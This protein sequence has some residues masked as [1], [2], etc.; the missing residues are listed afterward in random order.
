MAAITYSAICLFIRISGNVE[1]PHFINFIRVFAAPVITNFFFSDYSGVVSRSGYVIPYLLSLF[2][3]LIL[4]F[5]AINKK[6]IIV[7]A[8][9]WT[10]IILAILFIGI[11]RPGYVEPYSTFNIGGGER[12]IFYPI[13]MLLI[14]F[15]RH[16]D[17]NDRT[18]ISQIQ[19][20]VICGCLALFFLNA[21]ANYEFHPF[22]D[23]E[24][25]SY[26][27]DFD[28]KGQFSCIIPINPQ[29][30]Y[31][32]IP[33]NHNSSYYQMQYWHQLKRIE[34]GIMSIDSVG[35]KQYS[36][37]NVINID[38]EKERLVDIMGWAADNRA[39]DGTVKTY[40]VFKDGN[41]EIIIPTRKTIRPDVATYFGFES[42]IQSGWSATVS[43][44]QFDSKCYNISLRILRANGLEYYELNGEKPICF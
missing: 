4:I 14:L 5:S 19:Y 24:F 44:K 28:P 9:L 31:M 1:I 3:L 33:C 18:K 32:N 20:L 15:I 26:A 17:V 6:D 40:L 39:K 7:D 43:S 25:K 8:W 22:E 29:G 37:E 34:G 42:Y 38:K 27:E 2:V 36:N 21:A 16:I 23:L 13:T 11:S 35:K 10:L 41:E 30:W 12:Y